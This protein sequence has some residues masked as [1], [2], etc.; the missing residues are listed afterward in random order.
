MFVYQ[1]IILNLFLW[2][3]RDFMGFY[4][5]KNIKVFLIL[6]SPILASAGRP[7]RSTELEV[8]QPS[9]STDVHRTCTPVWLEGR[10]TDPVD[11][12]RA[13]LSGKPRSTGSVDRQRALLSVPGQGRPARSTEAP[14]VGF[15]I[16]G[17]RP[18]RSTDSRP[19]C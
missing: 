10:S 7:D 4:Q 5:R 11:R 3:F 17:G 2:I 6:K 12:Q 9:W 16:I 18:G 8:G 19:G 13:L 1:S 15:L 14:T